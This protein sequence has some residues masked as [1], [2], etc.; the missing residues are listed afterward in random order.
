MRQVA[1]AVIILLG[2][3]LV[4]NGLSVFDVVD[5]SNIAYSFEEIKTKK[6]FSD[7]VEKTVV[8]SWYGPGFYGKK[9]ASGEIYEEDDLTA[10]HRTLPFGTH[11]RVVNPLNNKSVIVRINDRGPFQK[12]REID[13]SKKA[14]E[15][16][17]LIK[18]GVGLVKIQ[19]L[20]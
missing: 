17:G 19:V 16:I 7:H 9:T 6:V 1:Y 5:D 13:L 2:L 10:A 3:L 4:I 11:V 18:D 8:A 12:D 14:A 15:K 20:M